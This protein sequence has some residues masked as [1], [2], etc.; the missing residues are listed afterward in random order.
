MPLESDLQGA[1]K[2]LNRLQNIYRFNVTEFSHGNIMGHQ[3][4]AEL[5]VKDTFYLG[6]FAHLQN[7]PEIAIKWL[8][9]AA[10]QAAADGNNTAVKL[11]QVEQVIKAVERKLPMGFRE[12]K[13]EEQRQAQE[14]NHEEHASAS[15]VP[16][17]YRLHYVPPKSNDMRQQICETDE[18][19]LAA[20]CRGLDILPPKDRAKLKC[21]YIRKG[22]GDHKLNEIF[23]EDLY[24]TIRPIKMEIA[25]P[26]PH[27]ILIFHDVI[28]DAESDGLINQALPRINRASVGAEKSMSEIRVSKNTWLEDDSSP[29]L[30]KVSQRI[31]WLTGMQTYWKLDRVG[32]GKKEEF[33]YLQV[34]AFLK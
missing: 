21:Y 2:A 29:I 33:E 24:F 3:T 14:T 12:L 11:S 23:G 13:K 20:L 22:L 4:S 15:V 25:H 28:S 7:N 26:E 10:F 30:D 34:M 5:G 31:D 18:I 6:R 8:E 16:R 32:E 27:P 19:N 1:A 17:K 9:Q